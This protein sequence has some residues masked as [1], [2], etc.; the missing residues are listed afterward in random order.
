MQDY[1]HR[2]RLATHSN[3]KDFV[4]TAGL[5]FYPL[6][7]DPKVL[8]GCMYLNVSVTFILETHTRTH[9]HTRIC[10]Y[11]CLVQMHTWLTVLNTQLLQLSL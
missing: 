8:A 1:G 2:V 4:L 7:G 5:E 3:F 10:M 11:M 6:G 9:T